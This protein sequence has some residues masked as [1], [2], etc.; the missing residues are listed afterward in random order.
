MTRDREARVGEGVKVIFLQKKAGPSLEEEPAR[1][2]LFLE[3]KC[4]EFSSH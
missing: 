4:C 2:S 3:G 1:S